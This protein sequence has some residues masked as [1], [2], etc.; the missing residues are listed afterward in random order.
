M[1]I[2]GGEA[3]IANLKGVPKSIMKEVEDAVNVSATK[4]L[5][6]A[7]AKV[8]GPVLGQVTGTLKRKLHNPPV[9]RSESGVMGV[10]GI[11]LSYA[12]AHEF[13]YK[14]QGTATVKAHT[15]RNLTQIKEATR[16]RKLKDGATQK[17]IGN[18]SKG[19]WAKNTEP[20]QGNWRLGLPERSFLRSALH[21][22]GPEIE[23][24]INE[25]VNRGLYI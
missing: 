15:R 19:H 18:K 25:A 24:L 11:K 17:Y 4:V 6:L 10:V 5:Q 14:G 9:R 1:K 2:S 22:L 20:R 3:L 7:K 21:E 13:G 16:F 23:Q 8:S 12:A